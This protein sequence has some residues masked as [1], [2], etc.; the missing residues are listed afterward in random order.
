MDT[1]FYIRQLKAGVDFGQRNH[2][3]GQ[4]ANFIYLVGDAVKKECLVVDPAWDIRGDD[5]LHRIRHTRRRD[6]RHTRRR[7]RA[8]KQHHSIA[9]IRKDTTTSVHGRKTQSSEGE[10][11]E[12]LDNRSGS[13]RRI[14]ESSYVQRR[15]CSTILR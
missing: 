3:A 6:I 10:M 11:E 5:V 2:I 15:T 8:Q 9:G 1:Q 13:R 14:D 12:F 4:M 7:R